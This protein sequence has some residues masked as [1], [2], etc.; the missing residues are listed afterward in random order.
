MDAAKNILLPSSK[1]N[2]NVSYVAVTDQY[3]DH[4]PG[5]FKQTNSQLDMAL[6]GPGFFGIST[7]E[8]A[9]I[10]KKRKF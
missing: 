3:T 5:I 1:S 4:K 2:K 9:S 10:Y 7:A 6:D 8:G